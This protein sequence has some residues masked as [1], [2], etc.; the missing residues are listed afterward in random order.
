MADIQGAHHILL[1]ILPKANWLNPESTFG[2]GNGNLFCIRADL[3][4]FAEGFYH[5]SI[6]PMYMYVQM[7]GM[8]AHVVTYLYLLCYARLSGMHAPNILDRE[9]RFSMLKVSKVILDQVQRKGGGVVSSV[10]K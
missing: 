5:C 1:V 3:L 7:Y 6:I 9:A 8:C 2:R 4:L 10:W